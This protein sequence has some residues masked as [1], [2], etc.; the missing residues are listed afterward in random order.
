MCPDC[1][2]AHELLRNVAFDG[3]K[4]RRTKHFQVED[5]EA[6]LKRQS[7]CSQQYHEREVT[8]FFLP[9][10]SNLRL[11]GLRGHGSQESCCGST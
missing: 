8:R 5:Y 2:N 1:V 11:S 6:L 3:H 9:R 7:F 10:V 4:V